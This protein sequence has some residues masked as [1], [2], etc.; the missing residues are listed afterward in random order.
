[1][2][3]SPRPARTMT[4]EPLTEEQIAQLLAL[5]RP[6]PVA[7]VAAA[8]ELPSARAELDGLVARA[9]QDAEFRREAIC[10][11]EQA[12]LAEGIEPSPTL[13]RELARRLKS[14]E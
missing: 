9:E 5:L 6:A 11:L 1:M 7:W 3:G 2:R 10:N 4:D 14:Q 12:L 13:Q 8:K